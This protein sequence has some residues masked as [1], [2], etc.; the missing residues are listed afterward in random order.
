MSPVRPFS[1]EPTVTHLLHWWEVMLPPSIFPCFF[2][3]FACIDVNRRLFLT[4]TSIWGKGALAAALLCHVPISWFHFIPTM[5]GTP[6]SHPQAYRIEVIISPL[7]R[8]CAKAAS[9]IIL[10][11]TDWEHR[12]CWR[13]R[14]R[15]GGTQLQVKLDICWLRYG[16]RTLHIPLEQWSGR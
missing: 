11:R 2:F 15:Q 3:L 1:P 13:N 9:P 5:N 14:D 6:W 8:V 16:W 7:L 4:C 12:Q 10:E